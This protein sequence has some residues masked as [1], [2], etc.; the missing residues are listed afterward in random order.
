[1]ANPTSCKPS[2]KSQTAAA[3]EE[4]RERLSSFVQAAMVEETPTSDFMPPAQHIAANPSAGEL[5]RWRKHRN[6]PFGG[7]GAEQTGCIRSSAV[8]TGILGASIMRFP[9]LDLFQVAV[10]SF[11]AAF[12]VGLSFLF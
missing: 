6:R 9:R 5:A 4:A 12:F 3:A 1:M 8:K 11:G 7:E 10:V 2:G